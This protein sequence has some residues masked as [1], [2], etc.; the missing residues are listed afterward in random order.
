LYHIDAS[1]FAAP[2]SG[3]RHIGAPPQPRLPQPRRATSIAAM[4][5]LFISTIAQ[6]ALDA[7]G[8]GIRDRPRESN[9]RDLL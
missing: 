8:I 2:S 5:T 9:P 6:G 7:C 3:A 4:S 1:N